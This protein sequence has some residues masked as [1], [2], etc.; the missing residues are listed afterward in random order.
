MFHGRNIIRN[1]K[2]MAKG[3][4]NHVDGEVDKVKK[5]ERSELAELVHKSLNKASADGTKV[6]YFL[7]EEEDPSMVTDWVSTGS[8]LLD[9]A[10]SNRKNGGLPVGRIVEISS[11]EAAG[12]SLICA[13]ILAATQKMGG[14]GVLIDTENAAS[15]E[16]WEAVGLDV[17]N[18]GYIPLNTVES[19][20]AKI[21]EV[22]GIVR[23]FDKKQLVTIVVDSLSQASSD[24]EMESEHG[25][26]GYNTSKAIIISKACRK[27]TGLIGQQRILVIFVNQLRM[28]LAAVGHQDKWIVPGGKAMAFAAS[29]RLRLS[30]MGKLKGAG[31]KIIGN[32]CKVVVT[33]NRMGPPHRAALFEIHYDS[34][35]QDL[36]SWLDF[37]KENGFAKKDGEKHAI[38]LP[39]E[40]VKL[41]T[42][43]FLEKIH[44][45]PSFKDQIYDVIATDYIMK[46]KPANSEILEGLEVEET[47]DGEE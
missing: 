18:L 36:T 27:I 2:I 19:I 28:N 42:K 15:P 37:L 29:V 1:L 3:K 32:K 17:K 24:T 30:N 34:G 7:D 10:I 40:T 5:V 4:S 11:Q 6:S 44:T 14:Y 31:Q 23:K 38:K 12:K 9:L 16:F 21:E 25:K 13:H 43:E 41:S 45:E 20:F 26:D 8:T 22:I 46:Y 47:V 33:K 39:N 35:I